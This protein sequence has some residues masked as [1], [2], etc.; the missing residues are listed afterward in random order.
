[1]KIDSGATSHFYDSYK[2]ALLSTPVSKTNLSIGVIIPNGS[3]MQST[4]TTKLPI[5]DLPLTATRAHGFNHLASGSLL[6]VGQLCD[7]D[8]T[9]IFDKHQV[10]IFKTAQVTI[11]LRLPPILT[12]HC[13]AHGK[14]WNT[15]IAPPGIKVL[16]HNSR[17]V[18]RTG[19]K[20][21][22]ML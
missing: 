9:A 12:G 4:C 6:S 19:D 7:H 3:I 22:P 8:C 5:P 16:A 2:A 11:Q 21:L 18:P 1:M 13:T 10:C 14:L 17:M 15:P 20:P